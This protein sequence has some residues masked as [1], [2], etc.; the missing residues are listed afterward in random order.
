VIVSQYNYLERT[1]RDA[2]HNA[3]LLQITDLQSL[4]DGIDRSMLYGFRL[5]AAADGGA[6]FLS[7]K[8]RKN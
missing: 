7:E 4:S 5:F 6:R 3:F 8:L 1:E 2:M